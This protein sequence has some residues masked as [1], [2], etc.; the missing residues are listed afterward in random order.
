MVIKSRNNQNDLG[1]LGTIRMKYVVVWPYCGNKNAAYGDEMPF[2]ERN[3]K[4][5]VGTG[6]F[7]GAYVESMLACRKISM[8]KFH[9]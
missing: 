7:T 5:K 9:L 8:A 6:S 4:A 3:E 2:F 1:A